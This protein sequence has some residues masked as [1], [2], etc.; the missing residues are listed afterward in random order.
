[1][2]VWKV[3]NSGNSVEANPKFTESSQNA[4]KIVAG[5]A[6]DKSSYISKVAIVSGIALSG[7]I[8]PIYELHTEIRNNWQVDNTT[9]GRAFE[10]DRPIVYKD[11]YDINQSNIDKQ[12]KETNGKIDKLI[13]KIDS[14]IEN[15]AITKNN[16]VST[17]FKGIGTKILGAI[18][19]ITVVWGFLELTGITKIINK[20]YESLINK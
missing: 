4:E 15:D 3:Y 5:S 7:V 13:E 20:I 19:T 1:M 2:N 10:M 12:F 11:V 17:F 16:L 8:S 6:T 18:T 14:F 9:E